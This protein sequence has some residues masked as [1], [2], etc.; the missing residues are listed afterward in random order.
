MIQPSAQNTYSY[1]VVMMDKASQ[2]L[3]QSPDPGVPRS[4][5]AIADHNGVPRSTLHMDV[6]SSRYWAD[7]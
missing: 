1:H 3:A 2:V 4:Y 5:R 7:I 6:L